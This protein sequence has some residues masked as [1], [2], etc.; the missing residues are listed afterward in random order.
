MSTSVM[1]IIQSST[2][3]P[4]IL[5]REYILSA[6]TMMAMGTSVQIIAIKDPALF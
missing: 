5:N 3:M 4:F 2:P 6:T 1:T